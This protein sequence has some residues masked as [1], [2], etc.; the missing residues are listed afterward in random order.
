MNCN[1]VSA[2]NSNIII[3]KKYY[4]HVCTF[5]NYKEQLSQKVSSG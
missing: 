2:N 4:V 1:G 5:H 3:S